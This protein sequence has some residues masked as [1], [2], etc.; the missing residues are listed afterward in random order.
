MAFN[1][2]WDNTYEVDPDDGANPGFG[3]EEIRDTRKNVRER[4]GS[5]HQVGESLSSEAAAADI[6][7]SDSG[8]HKQVTLDDGAIDGSPPTDHVRI[9]NDSGTLKVRDSGGTDTYLNTNTASGTPLLAGNDLNDVDTAA[10]ARTNL[11]VAIGSDVQAYDANLDN[12]A[13]LGTNLGHFIIG[14]GAAWSSE[15]TAATRVVLG[16]GTMALEDTDTT[17]ITGG[18]IT[19]ITDLVVAD[20]GT[21][22]STAANARTNLGVKSTSDVADIAGLTPTDGNFIVADGANWTA[23]SGA[24]TRT[25]LGLG[26]SATKD[27]GTTSAHVASGDHSNTAHSE[28][29]ITSAGVTYE[30]LSANSDIGTGST[31]VSQGD[32]THSVYTQLQQAQYYGSGSSS[33]IQQTLNTNFSTLGNGVIIKWQGQTTPSTTNT[34]LSVKLM[35][36]DFVNTTLDTQTMPT[37]ATQWWN[38]KL[39][40]LRTG[41]ASYDYQVVMQ[42]LTDVTLNSYAV[43]TVNSVTYGGAA[44]VNYITFSNLCS[45]FWFSEEYLQSDFTMNVS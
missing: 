21:G 9:H 43:G 25:S 4:L 30:N 24:T 1:E 17:T 41:A 7:A 38:I 34:V 8:Y 20:G 39:I 15:G 37:S 19:G 6:A 42:D 5:D 12:L 13:A 40:M 36:S 32:H 11:G 10:T 27:V 28:T 2:R 18:T 29:Y 26:D 31:Q 16:L 35:D 22:A 23:E 44:F 3:G 14:D 45:L 33:T